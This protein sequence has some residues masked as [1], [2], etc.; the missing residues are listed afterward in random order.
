MMKAKAEIHPW[1]ALFGRH[2][3]AVKNSAKLVYCSTFTRKEGLAELKL[4]LY[5]AQCP[6]I[7]SL[8]IRFRAIEELR[9]PVPQSHDLRER[10][11]TI[12]YDGSGLLRRWQ[13]VQI[14]KITAVIYYPKYRITA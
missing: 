6:Y 10:I 7:Y 12:T 5:A 9:R 4:G 3:E 13:T 14:Q 11:S 8:A 2:P 1:P